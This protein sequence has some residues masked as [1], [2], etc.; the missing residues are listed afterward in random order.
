MSGGT[1]WDTIGECRIIFHVNLA[2][3]WELFSQH[4]LISLRHRVISN[5]SINCAFPNVFGREKPQIL[6][7]LLNSPI[8]RI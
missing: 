1:F 2:E 5:G 3:S 4:T 7:S 6:H 8:G